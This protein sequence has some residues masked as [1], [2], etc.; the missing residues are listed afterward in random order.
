MGLCRAEAGLPGL[1]PSPALAA[2][3]RGAG[4]SSSIAPET[5]VLA[6]ARECPMRLQAGGSLVSCT[7]LRLCVPFLGMKVVSLWREGMKRSLG[8]RSGWLPIARG[9]PEGSRLPGQPAKQQCQP[10]GHAGLLQAQI[11]PANLFSYC[12]F[13]ELEIKFFFSKH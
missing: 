4:G 10:P 1:P 12:I 13:L 8:L 7:G 2:G 9:L 5:S 6:A 3:R 11:R